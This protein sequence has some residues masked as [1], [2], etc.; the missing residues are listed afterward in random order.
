MNESVSSLMAS[1]PPGEVAERARGDVAERRTV[2]LE[3]LK[4]LK[5]VPLVLRDGV[6][7]L[8]GEVGGERAGERPMQGSWGRAS[9][10]GLLATTALA[11]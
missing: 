6:V 10:N 1:H 2:S 7:G 11:I 3:R 4:Q 5:G 9:M 8:E